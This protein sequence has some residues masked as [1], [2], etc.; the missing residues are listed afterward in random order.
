MKKD[1]GILILVVV[2]PAI[3]VIIIMRIAVLN[4]LMMNEDNSVDSSDK[5]DD[6]LE[7]F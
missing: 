2:V 6:L 3:I 5:I 4:Y 1:V 7:Y